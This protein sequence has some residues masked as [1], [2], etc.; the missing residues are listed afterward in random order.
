MK[1]TLVLIIAIL[2]ATGLAFADGHGLYGTP[3]GEWQLQGNR[4]Y[5]QDEEAMR[6]KAWFRVPQ[7]GAMIYEF[8]VRYE[9]GGEDGHGG[10]GIHILADA[11]TDGISWG[12]GD[13]WMLWVNYDI[14]ANASGVPRG[15][16]ATLYKSDSHK[17]ME[18][19]SSVDLNDYLY[20]LL[21]NIDK[22]IPV[23]ITF[24]P[25]KGRISIAD[26]RG[27]TSGWYI[28]IPGLEDAEG[29]YVAVRTNSISASFTSPDLSM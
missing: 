15:F 10:T 2:S 21:D 5:Q 28:D 19:V 17:V 25:S 26:P 20:L 11:K 23:K 7:N 16:S 3:E 27:E 14:N 24:Y 29:S 12:L 4:L 8:T 13:S 9:G 6:A 18:V 22:D 1:R